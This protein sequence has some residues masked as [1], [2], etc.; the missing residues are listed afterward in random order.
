MTHDKI[1]AVRLARRAGETY[2]SIASKFGIS[3]QW[4]WD[5]CNNDRMGVK[6]EIE[7]SEFTERFRNLMSGIHAT[8]V[9]DLFGTSDTC[10]RDWRRGKRAPSPERRKFVLEQAE[11]I[12]K[13]RV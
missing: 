3:P 10:I 12:V 11:R 1:H 7:R 8:D 4:A 2:K 5:V 9:A 6:P 13:Q